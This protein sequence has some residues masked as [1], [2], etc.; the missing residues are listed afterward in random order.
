MGEPALLLQIVIVPALKFGKR[1]TFE[2]SAVGAPVG[3]FPCGR[4]G[5]IFAKFK[6]MRFR[7]F[8]PRATDAHVAVRFVLMGK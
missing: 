7:W 6:W 1:M 5:A 8:C 4:L 3:H 2:K